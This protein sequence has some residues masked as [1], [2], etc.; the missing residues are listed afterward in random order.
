M[1]RALL[2]GDAAGLVSPVTAGGIHTALVDGFAAGHAGAEFLGGRSA[3]PQRSFVGRYPRFCLK[4]LLRFG[5]DHLQRD[6]LF[7]MGLASRPL[8]WAP[9]RLHFPKR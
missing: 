6:W 5:F 9:G 8:R 3:D 1:P 2:V 4:R 7:N